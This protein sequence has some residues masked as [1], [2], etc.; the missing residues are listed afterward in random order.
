M[1]DDNHVTE[2]LGIVLRETGVDFFRYRRPTVLRR[3]HNRMMSLRIACPDAYLARLRSDPAESAGLA[4]RIT[5]KVSR[6]YRNAATFD[7]LRREVLPAL[8]RQ[9]GERAL[10]LWS[11]GCGCGEEAYT[12]AMLLDELDVEGTVDATDI[13]PAALSAAACGTYGAAALG[14]LPTDL[15]TQYTEH[16]P[17]PGDSAYTVRD[18]IRQRVRFLRHDLTAGGGPRAEARYDLIACRNVL[19]Y[20]QPPAQHDA[21]AALIGCLGP[22]GVLCLGEAEWPPAPLAA[23]LRTI[24]Q[25]HRLFAVSTPGKEPTS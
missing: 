4:E 7:L 8:V 22:G 3:I 17:G 11:A 24:H 6:F 23:S 15:A 5:I 21:L 19:I 9:R 10:R 12:L 13:D 2:M 25:R 14:E 20:L 16:R 18:S 1:L